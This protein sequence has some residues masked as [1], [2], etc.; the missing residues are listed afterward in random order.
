VKKRWRRWRAR[1]AVALAAL[2]VLAVVA[3]A[4]AG[5]QGRRLAG[6]FCV[7][8]KTGVVRSVSARAKC[9]RREVRK[10][11]LAVPRIPGPPGPPGP[12]GPQGPPGSAADTAQLEQR[13]T[14]LEQKVETLERVV[15]PNA[16]VLQVCAGDHGALL[17][18]DCKGKRERYA[19]LLSP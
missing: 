1:I 9:H 15:G 6:P 8:T 7:S 12:A 18:G 5:D 11:G 10:T 16:S 4:A 13:I 3:G 14:V 2:V 19:L 17:V